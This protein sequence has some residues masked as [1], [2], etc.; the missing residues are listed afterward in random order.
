MA[1]QLQQAYERNDYV[2]VVAK[3]DG[4]VHAMYRQWFND[5]GYT[6]P[7]F[8]IF[9][10]SEIYMFHSGMATALGGTARLLDS[11]LTYVFYRLVPQRDTVKPVQMATTWDKMFRDYTDE[12][13]LEIPDKGDNSEY[14]QP[15]MGD[16][17]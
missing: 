14:A 11:R 4:T 3:V 9:T 6:A 10:R 5:Q 8:D 1:H 15:M 17:K 2:A 13:L 16:S 12:V 7:E